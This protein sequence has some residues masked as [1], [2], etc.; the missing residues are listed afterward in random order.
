MDIEILNPERLA[1]WCELIAIPAEAAAALRE[2]AAQ[3]N[4]QPDLRAVFDAF[5]EK[6]TL[7]GEWHREWSALDFDPLVSARLGED[8]SLFYLLGYLSG[9]PQTWEVY[10]RRGVGLDIF[11]A[12]LLD[13]R[14]FIE[15][16]HDLH[17]RWGFSEFPWMWRHLTA[18]LFRLGRLQYM[19]APFSGGV[20][21]L[22]RRAGKAPSPGSQALGSPLLLADPAQALRED[23]C[24]WAAGQPGGYHA[25]PGP[26]SWFPAFESGPDGWRGHPVSPYGQAQ[27]SEVFLPASEW[28]VVLQKGDVVLDLHIPRKDPL[29]EETCGASYAAAL[30]FFAR[31]F[32]ERPPRA[33]F[34]H[35]W[36]F[37][38]QLQQILPPTSNLV[39][40]QREFYLYPS[41]GSLG[42]LWSFVFG[43]K[44]PERAAAPRDTSLRRAV[45]D[46]LDQGGEIFD[47]PGLM[48]HPPAEWG[49]QP[50]MRAWDSAQGG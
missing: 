43:P 42:F 46:W 22:R 14:F 12:T 27:R 49:S 39:R 23:G 6:T 29:N 24:A 2:T 38:P 25:V 40:F 41:A 15:D 3:V 44:Y 47:L 1:E 11:K 8:A 50:S 26:G 32:P 36:M 10:Q 34:C 30:A 45:L 19:L 33:L 16:Y 9:L 28:E 4:S 13:F 7:R 21:A 5:H 35:T 37:S 48:F 17:G 20:T 18:D 31:V